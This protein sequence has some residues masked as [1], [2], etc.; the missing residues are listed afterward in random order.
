[1]LHGAEWFVWQM[2]NENKIVI[3]VCETQDQ[4]KCK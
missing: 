1:M 4:N 3:L 2:C